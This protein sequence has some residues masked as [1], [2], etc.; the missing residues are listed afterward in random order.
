MAAQRAVKVHPTLAGPRQW[1]GICLMR[2]GRPAEAIPEIEQ[3]IRISPRN[4]GIGGRYFF[5]GFALLFSERYDEAIVW[6]QRSLAANPNERASRRSNTFAAIAAAHALAGQVEQSRSNAAEAGRLRPGITV[7]SYFP[8]N[9]F[10]PSAAPQVSRL[11]VGLRLAGIR[12]HADEDADAG[13]VSDDALHTDYE[14]P[15]PTTVPGARTIRTPDLTKLLELRKPLVLDT[16]DLGRS[17][18]GAIGLWAAGIGGSMT[19]E[20]QERL[21]RKLQQLTGGDRTVP[22]VTVGFNS[23]RHQGRNLALRLAALGYTEVYWYRGGRE[24]WQ[25]AGLP[26]AE[27]V[28]Q[29]W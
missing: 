6:W 3:A 8:F 4:P 19:D 5:L 10:Q 28:V 21:G 27:L 13:L 24:A 16:F 9:I 14:T 26:D 2:M 18:P 15:T 11:H 22:I 17:V 7:R 23:E 20:Y 12:D 1:A 29:D 25:A